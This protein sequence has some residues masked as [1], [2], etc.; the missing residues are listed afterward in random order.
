LR[1]ENLLIKEIPKGW[2]VVTFQ[3]FPLGWI[4]GIGHRINN[5]F[6]RSL[7]VLKSQ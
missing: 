2:A 4:K 5:Y 1:C 3:N 6:P 7:R